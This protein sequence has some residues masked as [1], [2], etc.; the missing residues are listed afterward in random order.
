MPGFKALILI[1]LQ[2]SISQHTSFHFFFHVLVHFER[3]WNEGDLT[4]NETDAVFY[5]CNC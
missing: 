2:S 3:A 5:T 4:S 1:S